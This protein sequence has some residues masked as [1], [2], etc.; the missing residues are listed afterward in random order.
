MF[1]VIM[2]IVLN[3]YDFNCGWAIRRVYIS[4]NKIVWF[5]DAEGQV[6]SFGSLKISQPKT[7]LELKWAGM[8]KRMR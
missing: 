8:G 7:Y 4:A 3:K 5:A 2:V 6:Y 1:I